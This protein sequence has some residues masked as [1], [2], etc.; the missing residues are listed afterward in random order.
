MIENCRNNVCRSLKITL[1]CYISLILP[2]MALNR[3][4]FTRII[5]QCRGCFD[6]KVSA[7]SEVDEKW[8]WDIIP[9]GPANKENWQRENA[10]S[11]NTKHSI[12]LLTNIYDSRLKCMLNIWCL[13]RKQTHMHFLRFCGIL[14]TFLRY[15]Y[16]LPNRAGFV[17][18]NHY[19]ITIMQSSQ[20][21][22]VNLSRNRRKVA[23][24][25]CTQL[26]FHACALKVFE[27]MGT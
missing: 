7:P 18:S 2:A 17:T 23:K 26:N 4:K 8:F 15:T 11:L 12:T 19:F 5:F 9:P 21:K 10:T 22:K 25:W 27:K 6:W 20:A 24:Q 14:P 1:E 3:A 16:F 13:L